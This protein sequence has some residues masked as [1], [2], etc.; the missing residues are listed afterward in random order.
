MLIAWIAK[1]SSMKLGG[2][3]IVASATCETSQTANSLLGLAI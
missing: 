1:C 2:Y 3:N